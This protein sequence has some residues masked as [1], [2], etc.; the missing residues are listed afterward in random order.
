MYLVTA[1]EMREIDRQTIE[2][3]GIPGIV[4]MENAGIQVVQ[5]IR[6]RVSAHYNEVLVLTSHGNNGGDGFVIARHL[7][8]NGFNVE[9]WFIGDIRKCS[10]DSII[11]FHALVHSG[12][13]LKFWDEKNREV[14]EAKI[15]EADII[16]DAMLG[17][18]I[19]GALREP[20]KGVVE[21]VNLSSAYKVAVDIPTGVNSDTGEAITAFRADLTVTLGFP[22]LGQYL[23]IGANYVG[24]LEVVDIAI[25]PIIIEKNN[26][27][28]YLIT[29]EI[30]KEFLPNRKA[31][32]HKGNYGHAL[33]IG[34]SKNMPGAPT[35]AAFATLR[36]G[37]GLST[38]AVPKSIQ[39]AVFS[40]LPEVICIGLPETPS[41]HFSVNS[42]EELYLANSKYTALGIGPGIGVWGYGI[43][44]LKVI[45]TA[46]QPI[47]L[48]AD[49]LNLLALDLSLLAARNGPTIITPHPGE[50][51]RLINNDVKFV[52][53]NRVAVAQEFSQKYGVYVALKGAN[54]IIATPEGE[55]YINS[56]GGPELAKGGTGDVLTGILTGLIAQG[57]PIRDSVVAGVYLHGLAGALASLPS[58]YS[59]IASE[60]INNLS[61]AIQ[62][63]M[64]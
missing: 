53:E 27:K 12:Y 15:N 19:S 2:G 63:T 51:A 60:V 5:C 49:A 3:I 22:K 56:T 64:S 45:F 4:L 21:N 37:A 39:Q 13:R 29:K 30:V 10:E 48:D 14:L 61:L 17:T 57:L 41:G 16:I 36:S 40:G 28:R 59:T 54:S 44:W 1:K 43:D 23:Y 58:N 47:V 52:E 11:N 46:S 8:N 42:I 50:M 18:G 34:G 31:N 62:Q 38:V 55:I 25:P 9:T 7:A 6:K 20:L 26:P 32:S 24:D 35:L 33:I